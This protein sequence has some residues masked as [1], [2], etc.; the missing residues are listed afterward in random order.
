M[1]KLITKKWKLLFALI[2]AFMC[3]S[4]QSLFA[5]CGPGETGVDIIIDTTTGSFEEET[6]WVL[7]NS[8]GT[9]VASLDCMGYEEDADIIDVTSVCLVAG[10]SY[11]FQAFDTFGDGWNGQ[12]VEILGNENGDFDGC[13]YVAAFSPADNDVG[14]LPDNAG[15]TCI[16]EGAEFEDEFS[17]TAGV[18]NDDISLVGTF[19]DNNGCG[20]TSAEILTVAVAAGCNGVNAGDAEVTVSITDGPNGP[21]GPIVESLP[22]I[23]PGATIDFPVSTTFDLSTL[24]AYTID[25]SVNFTVASEIT[26]ANPGDNSVT[27]VTVTA[28]D[29]FG[30]IDGENDE[31]VES[32]EAGDGGWT[33]QDFSTNGST[34]ALGMPPVQTNINGASDGTQAWFSDLA[35]TNDTTDPIDEQYNESEAIFFFSGC[36]D[37]SCM[38]TATFSIDVN[39]DCETNFDGASVSFSTDGGNTFTQLGEGSDGTSAGNGTN[40]YNN[41]DISSHDIFGLTDAPGWSGDC[42]GT[43]TNCSAMKEGAVDGWLTATHNI[44]FLAGEPSVIFSVVFTSDGSLQ[45]GDGFA[46]DNIQIIEVTTNEECIGCTDPEADNY[47]ELAVYDDESCEYSGCTDPEACNYDE[48][49]T[50]D[51]ESCEYTTCAGCTDE[52][53]CNYDPD[54][55]IDDGSCSDGE[56]GDGICNPEC[57]ET[58]ATCDDCANDVFGCDD[59]LACN[60][61]PDATINDESC[62]YTTCAGCTDEDACNYDPDATIEDD[63]CIFGECGNGICEAE[64]GETATT[65][66]DCTI[67]LGCTD[68]AAHNYRPRANT[69][70]PDNPCQ[71]CDDGIQNGSE[72]GL[73]CGGTKCDPCPVPVSGCMDETAHNYNADAEVDDGSCETCTDGIMNGDETGVDC[74]GSL[75]APCG[76]SC[77]TALEISCG[78]VVSENTNDFS[79]T[80][81]GLNCGSVSS[82]A[83]GVWYV[84]EGTGEN[85]K[86]STDNDGGDY[87]TNLQVFT[88]G[89]EALACLDGA[90]DGAADNFVNYSSELIFES[91]AGTD[92][93]IYVS[94]WSGSQGTYVMTLGC[95]TPIQI[96][97]DAVAG[98]PTTAG[99]GSVAVTVT[100]G[101]TDC[102]SLTYSWTGPGGFAAS[103]ED[104]SGLSMTGDYTLTV[105]DCLGNTETM[106]VNVPNRN[107]RRGRRG[108]KAEIIETSQLIAAPNPFAN[109]TMISFQV[110]T[111]ETV[112]L[113]VFDI[114]GAKVATLFDGMAEAGQNYQVQFGEA[115]PSGTYI[116]KLTTANGHVQHIKLFLA[117]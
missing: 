4:E 75:C 17:F 88:G 39:W 107:G 20:F 11:T 15:V 28:F 65:C 89:C 1:T 46:F 103:T 93:Y 60:Y 57:G 78:D 98:V 77:A 36:F 27:G 80:N 90:E 5:Q 104:I 19:F 23:G 45:A 84:F 7:I 70:D 32:F 51:D 49:A 34:M 9:T 13:I 85:V 22:E 102:G 76:D 109:E 101:N 81:P 53:A 64:C 92:Y 82:P 97:L 117:K 47:N 95:F 58:A 42:V 8:E 43:D 55:T 114:R 87:D 69:D 100:G 61:N 106:T 108:G 50:I 3:C 71:T 44:D 110:G 111:E 115:M 112:S 2:A 86:L 74:G 63:S 52:D 10:E 94:G 68:P 6:G 62:E 59:E 35:L 25:I 72:T 66:S 83:E 105:T 18:F 37:M 41:L 26:D 56:C 54:A 31:Y 96:T 33:V 12:T 73:D 29:A 91:T 16:D 21:V 113:D 48:M 24:G 99:T 38:E 79:D 116:A 14:D 30:P 40:W 67:I